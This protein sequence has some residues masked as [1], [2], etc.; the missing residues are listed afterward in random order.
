MKM[1]IEL[2]EVNMQCVNKVIN[3]MYDIIKENS[4]KAYMK[5]S[6]NKKIC[7]NNSKNDNNFKFSI[8]LAYD[9]QHK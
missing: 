3:S 4:N 8:N 7:N 5:N 6:N 9:Y 1:C 2:E